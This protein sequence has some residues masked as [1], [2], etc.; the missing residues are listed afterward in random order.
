MP[1]S[2][3]YTIIKDRMVVWIF[4][5]QPRS[6]SHSY[7]QKL[8]EPYLLR[9]AINFGH[10]VLLS[11]NIVTTRVK[12]ANRV[13]KHQ[14]DLMPCLCSVLWLFETWRSNFSNSEIFAGLF[15]SH[16]QRVYRIPFKEYVPVPLS[17]IF[18][19]SSPARGKDSYQFQP[20]SVWGR[21]TLLFLASIYRLFSNWYT[22]NH[23]GIYSD[24]REGST[25]L[26]AIN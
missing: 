3:M 15:H 11:W 7:I 22:S 1:S 4:P 18:N 24:Y 5:I 20:Y 13:I 2:C 17:D 8:V 19:I 9:S 6:E 10:L 26:T 25:A 21:N 16:R 12:L 23:D 14:S